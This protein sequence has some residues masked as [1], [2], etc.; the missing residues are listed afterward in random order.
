MTSIDLRPLFTLEEAETIALNYFSSIRELSELPSERDQNFLVTANNYSRFVL[1]LSNRGESKGVLR[2]QNQVLN[3][4]KRN[5]SS[6]TVPEVVRSIKG[7]KISRISDKEDRKYFVR[8]LTYLPGQVM[9]TVDG[10]TDELQVDLGIYLGHLD[11]ALAGYW[12]PMARRPLLWSLYRAVEVIQDGKSYLKDSEQAAIVESFLNDFQAYVAPILN[13]LPSGVIHNDANDHNVIVSRSESG[14]LQIGGLIDFGDMLYGPYVYEPSVAAAYAMLGEGDVLAAASRIIDGYHRIFPLRLSEVEILHYLIAIRLCT[15]VVMSAMR[16]EMSPDNEYLMISENSAWHALYQLIALE[17]HQVANRFLEVCQL[18]P[19]AL[20]LTSN[21]IIE[22]RKK[23]LGPSLSTSYARPLNIVRGFRQYLYD[24]EGRRYLDAVNN[25]PHVGHCHPQVV[26]AGQYQMARLNTNTRYLHENIVRYAELL[27]DTLP[28]QLSVCYFVC[29][30]S[31]ANELA[32][33]LARTHTKRCDLVVLDGAYHGNTSLLVEISPYKFDGPG[34][35][36][37]TSHVHKVDMPDLYR[38]TYRYGDPDASSHYA[39]QIQRTVDKL[40]NSG[41]GIAAFISESLLGCGGQIVLPDGYLVEAYGIIRSGGGVC[42]ADEV[43][44]GF[45]R[46][47]SHFWGFQTQY[48]VPDIVTMGKPMGNG[49]PLAAVVTTPEIASSF[50]NGMEYF[51]TYG[52]NPVSCAIGMAVLEV[53]NEE[54]LQENALNVG[55]VFKD[56]LNQLKPKHPLIGDVRGLGLFLGIE[57]VRDQNTLEPAANEAMAVVEAMM[58]RGILISTDGPLHNV[59]KI[60]PPLVFS[61]ENSR[62][63]VSVLDEIL[64][65]IEN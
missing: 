15:S 30:G 48:V 60:K 24:Q 36:G 50:D 12:H 3:Q 31:E 38:G 14:K 10:P 13:E 22:L 21:Q 63:F 27:C 55:Q 20:E 46:V 47:G 28:E 18:S 39:Q 4:I 1:K 9:A 17:P 19:Q 42:I 59:L 2:F 8:L 7:K 41:K 58:Q 32:L 62:H 53:I 33:R 56:G 43:Q 40:Q 45:G 57:L 23:Q 54:K 29:S 11:K 64:S 61:Q 25:V 35:E 34:G 5:N 16:R 51:N 52:G 44:V 49:H 6:I 37:A 65:T 26:R